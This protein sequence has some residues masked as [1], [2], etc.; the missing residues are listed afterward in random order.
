MTE[1]GDQ[2]TEPPTVTEFINKLR[3]LNAEIGCNGE[4]IASHKLRSSVTFE[5][6]DGNTYRLK[7]LD[8]SRLPGCG[9]WDGVRVILE[10]KPD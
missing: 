8:I 6:A 9:C 3:G 2:T 4:R 7:D 5:D 10:R 1:G